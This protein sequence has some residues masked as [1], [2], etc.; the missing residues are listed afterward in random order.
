[1][2]VFQHRN[3][4]ILLTGHLTVYIVRITIRTIFQYIKDFVF[5]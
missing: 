4:V 1:M 5:I 3:D 2:G